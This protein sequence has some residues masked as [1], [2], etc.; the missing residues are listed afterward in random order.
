MR[1]LP[2]ELGT[3]TKDPTVPTS[4][5]AMLTISLPP[6]PKKVSPVVPGP[7]VSV[8]VPART[9]APSSP[10]WKVPF[11]TPA[12]KENDVAPP[13]GLTLKVPKQSP[14]VRVS[15]AQP[16]LLARGER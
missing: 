12:V 16:P 2:D 9:P 6:S 15:L 1:I 8:N 11:D 13:T 10:C 14:P 7:L 4:P 5:A 3:S